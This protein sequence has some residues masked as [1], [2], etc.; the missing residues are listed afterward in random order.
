M[1]TVRGA[2]GRVNEE[3]PDNGQESRFVGHLTDA[4]R[5]RLELPVV[6][7]N[8]RACLDARAGPPWHPVLRGRVGFAII[9]PMLPQLLGSLLFVTGGQAL[10]TAAPKSPTPTTQVRAKPRTSVRAKPKTQVRAKQIA[11]DPALVEVLTRLGAP[12][13]LTKA[14]RKQIDA[15][16][17]PEVDDEVVVGAVPGWEDFVGAWAAR[18]HS[19]DV[20]ALVQYVI[21]SA[22]LDSSED[23]REVAAKVAFYNEQ[24]RQIREALARTRA[25]AAKLAPGETTSVRSLTILPAYTPGKAPVV[26]GKRESKAAAD[27]EPMLTA[28]EATLQAVGE[29]A[30]LANL[31]LQDALQKQQQTL[32][33]MSNVSKVLHDTAM[34]VIQKIG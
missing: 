28:W 18:T 21:R 26:Y 22:Y 14:E 34:A 15:F 30:Q 2:Q 3:R 32:Q 9:A 4:G 24:K 6:A 12:V 29:D 1:S 11:L 19:G 10:A 33:T 25:S 16:V 7:G 13:P 23:L 31:D 20:D 5:G 27:I 8:E 17:L